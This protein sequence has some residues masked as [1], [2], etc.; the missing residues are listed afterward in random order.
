MKY[1]KNKKHKIK[2]KAKNNKNTIKK[3]TKIRK[4]GTRRASD[5]DA[6]LQQELWEL[7]QQLAVHEQ[8]LVS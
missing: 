7:Q 5:D 8:Q 1:T 2:C 6:K 4:N 3:Q